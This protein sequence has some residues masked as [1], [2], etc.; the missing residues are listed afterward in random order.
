MHLKLYWPTG[1]SYFT[2]TTIAPDTR[3][4][5]LRHHPRLATAFSSS[6][7]HWK[8]IRNLGHGI[9]EYRLVPI[10][11]TTLREAFFDRTPRIITRE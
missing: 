2:W 11:L 7:G 10:R 9:L 5:K 1:V 8:R 6:F 4:S 3:S